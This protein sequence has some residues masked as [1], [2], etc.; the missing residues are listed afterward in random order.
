MLRAVF[1]T[2]LFALPFGTRKLLFQFTPG[3][4]E[5][6]G[7]FLYASDILL[8]IFLMA[9]AFH[10]IK[11]QKSDIRNS[12]NVVVLCPERGR[13]AAVA[14]GAFLLLAGISLFFAESFG[15]AL[16]AFVR[17]VAA[18]GFAAG[19]A[20]VSRQGIVQLRRVLIV[21]AASA[22]VQSFIAFAQF[23]KQGS[24]G[25]WFLGESMLS[26]TAPGIAKFAAEG[27]KIVRAYGTFPHPNVLGAF[28]AVGLIS[29]CGIWISTNSEFRTDLRISR[30]PFAYS[31]YI[32]YSL[33]SASTFIIIL[34]LAL[35]FSRSA[36]LIAGT[37]VALL[38]A[39]QM[40]K[41]NI[42]NQND[43]NNIECSRQSQNNAKI[44]ILSLLITLS[45]SFAALLFIF[46]P[47]ILTRA[48]ISATEP[49]I[50]QRLE[51]NRLGVDLIAQHPFGVGIGNQVLYSV[52]NGLYQTFGMHKVWQWEPI[53]N[54]YLLIA[55][56]NGVLSLI[57]FILLGGA[58]LSTRHQ[59]PSF[60]QISNSNDQNRTSFRV[61]NFEH[62]NLFGIWDLKF[63][64][65]AM[66]FVAL[67]LFGLVDHFLWTLRPGQLLMWLVI[68]LL[69][70]LAG[71][72]GRVEV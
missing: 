3:L 7:V 43:A 2:I 51:Y 72:G 63:G 32:R 45:F 33:M 56:E 44:K 57:A 26:A 36:W 24:V 65:P 29:L 49:S 1:Y 17:L 64:A 38:I 40:Q 28:L 13:R 21:L 12:E 71:R 5:Y 9:A 66:M 41:S 61:L 47:F 30:L 19:I 20:Y 25:L 52:K 23:V 27:G 58:L 10:Y 46:K 22:V 55:A 42:K 18:A 54:M 15:L 34:G 59:T 16:Y 35:T 14:L 37:A 60:K 53:H 67:L 62:W 68:G 70:G 48:Q 31:H 6:E 4:H 39:A 11:Y 50:T 8:A 69:W